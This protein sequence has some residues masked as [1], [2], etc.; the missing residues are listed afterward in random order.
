MYTRCPHCHAIF[1]VSAAVLQ[2]AG[3]EV[4]CGVCSKVFNALDTLQD[5][6]T[7]DRLPV[8]DNPLPAIPV[9]TPDVVSEE[10][11]DNL[12]FSIPETEWQQFFSTT[13]SEE[14]PAEPAPPIDD[15]STPATENQA[16]PAAAT[17]DSRPDDSGDSTDPDASARHEDDSA[18]ATLEEETADTETWQGFLREAG[19]AAALPADTVTGGG[20][21]DGVEEAAAALTTTLLPIADGEVGESATTE[22]EPSTTEDDTGQPAATA[23]T[24][25]TASADAAADIETEAQHPLPADAPSEAAGITAAMKNEEEAEEETKEDAVIVVPGPAS[26][27][28][29]QEQTTGDISADPEPE[30]EDFRAEP[31]MPMLE[32]DQ[33][34]SASGRPRMRRSHMLLWLFASL[35]AAILL[36]GQ[37]VHHFRDSLAA[38]PL[39]GETIRTVYAKLDLPLMPEWSLEAYEIRSRRAQIGNA[40][41]A[42][43]DIMA[44]IAIGGDHPVDLPLLRVTLLDRWSNVTA[45]GLFGPD[46]YLAS[47]TA[48]QVLQQPGTSMSVRIRLQDPGDLATGYDLDIC[49]PSRHAGLRCQKAREPFRR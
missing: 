24:P 15:V 22:D 48:S 26:P 8:L 6:W 16:D 11:P 30:A 35:L 49:L 29:D 20:I 33:K 43:L 19:L 21:T 4:R 39:W 25:S 36:G 44:E 38:D 2:M 31:S 28:G 17:D 18:P 12:E 3:G 7:S 13:P 37:M 10:T 27:G 47:T 46:E 34:P 45:S 42:A 40:G 1:R 41:Q 32:W 14:R 5:D 9:Q 23:D